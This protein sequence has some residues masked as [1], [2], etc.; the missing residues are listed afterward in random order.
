MTHMSKLIFIQATV[1]QK[2]WVKLEG[3]IT[4]DAESDAEERNLERLFWIF[5]WNLILISSRLDNHY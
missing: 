4:Y 3:E 5:N 1:G 2:V